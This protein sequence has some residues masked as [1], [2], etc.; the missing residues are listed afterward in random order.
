LNNFLFSLKNY[1]KVKSFFLSYKQKKTIGINLKFKS[2]YPKTCEK[3]VLKIE[4][5]LNSYNIKTSLINLPVRIKRFTVLRS[6][7]ID[8][9]SREQFELKNYK[10]LINISCENELVGFLL[11]IVKKDSSKP[12]SLL[13]TL[14]IS[15]SLSYDIKEIID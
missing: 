9:K 10:Q 2:F 14:D 13:F 11:K 7:H 1:L 6:P 5:K 8:K 12:L 15:L 4:A 3:A